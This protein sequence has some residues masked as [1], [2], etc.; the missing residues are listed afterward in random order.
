MSSLVLQLNRRKDHLNKTLEQQTNDFHE[1][2]KQFE[3]DQNIFEK[4]YQSWL[5]KETQRQSS[6]KTG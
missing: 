1:K 2:K 6:L 4:E 3:E 5:D